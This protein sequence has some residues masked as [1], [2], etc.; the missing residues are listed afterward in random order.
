MSKLIVKLD[1]VLALRNYTDKAEPDIVM[2]VNECSKAGADGTN[3]NISKSSHLASGDIKRLMEET[4]TPLYFD[5]SLS[6]AAPALAK[7][8]NGTSVCFTLD[9]PGVKTK[10]LPLKIAGNAD[11]QKAL[12][13]FNKHAEKC[14]VFINTDANEIRKAKSAGFDFVQF[15]AGKYSMSKDPKVQ[16]E[17]L[18]AIG[19]AAE[20]AQELGL[21]VVVTGLI[22]YEN[23]KSLSLISSI[24]YMVVGYAIT[25]M[26]VLK[27]LPPAV[28]IMRQSVE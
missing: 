27:G 14:G 20:L 12:K 15:S 5:V 24:D 22:D 21:E 18:S 4:D 13:I 10:G 6:Q 7:K 3:F 8:L 19:I 1:Y 23:A 16:I 25:S 17:Q 11:A 26:A 28:K 2:V 9:N